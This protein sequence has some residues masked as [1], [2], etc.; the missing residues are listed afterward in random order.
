MRYEDKHNLIDFIH[1]SSPKYN[2][3]IWLPSKLV[4]KVHRQAE[5]ISN[6]PSKP[7][8]TPIPEAKM[9]KGTDSISKG[10]SNNAL[11]RRIRVIDIEG[12]GPVYSKTLGE[13]GINYIDEMLEA[14]ATRGKR[15]KLTEKPV[16]PVS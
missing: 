2:S 5:N 7:N 16:S 4:T 9:R 1:T 14:G 3:S 6:S 10:T 13:S 11:G 8:Q 12:V 15:Q